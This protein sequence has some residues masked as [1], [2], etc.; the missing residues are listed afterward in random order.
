MAN[1]FKNYIASSVG[2]GGD[3]LTCPA[4]ST[5]TIIGM[6]LANII[7][8]NIKVTSYCAVTYLTFETIITPGSSL[9]VVGGDQKVVLEAGDQ[10]YNYSDTASSM[11]IVISYMLTT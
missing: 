1:V 6:T 3:T 10:L 11:D 5:I 8:S 7:T 4:N 9:I 2:T